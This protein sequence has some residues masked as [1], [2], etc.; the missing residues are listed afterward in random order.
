[1]DSKLFLV[2]LAATGLM[3]CESTSPRAPAPAAPARSAPAQPSGAT[4]APAHGSAAS[5]AKP[6]EVPAAKADAPKTEVAM[7]EVA[8][9]AGTVE[10]RPP[11]GVPAPVVE[12]KP[13]SKPATTV[14][15]PAKEATPPAT[16][17]LVEGKPAAPVAAPA[18]APD[19]SPSIFGEPL[20]VNGKRV[21]DN[22]I[23]RYLIYGPCRLMLEMYRIDLI[24]QDEFVRRAAREADLVIRPQVTAYATKQASA[25]IEGKTFATPEEKQAAYD[26]ALAKAT[27]EARSLPELAKPWREAY[28]AEYGR[29]RETMA[30]SDVEFQA[31]YKRTLDEFRGNYPVLDVEAEVSRAFRTV[32]WY[33]TNLKQTLLFDKVFYPEDPADWPETTVE[34]VRADS[35]ET[36]L[37]DAVDSYQKRRAHADKTG[38][39][40]PKED[41]IYTQ[42]MRQIVRDALYSTIDFKTAYDGL[43]DD[44][45]MTA[46]KN[47]DGKPELVVTTAEVWEK[48]KD[49]VTPAEIEEAKQWYVTSIATADRLKADGHLLD[50]N[51]RKQA[52]ADLMK[53]FAGTYI[54]IEILATQQYAFPSTETYKEYFCLSKGFEALTAPK[55]VSGPDGALAAPLRDHLD[56]ANR[57]MG[58]GQVDVEC[59]LV[60]AFDIPHFKW[61][62]VTW[63]D[64]RKKAEGIKAQIDANL[65]ANKAQREAA[66]KARA[67]GKEFT[68]DPAVLEPYVFWT[69]MMDD[70]SEFWDPPPPEKGKSSTVGMKNRGRFGL[71]YRN[72]LAS[73]V[74]ETA[75]S[76]WVTG[77]SITDRTFFDQPEGVVE[78]PYKHPY[79]YLLTRVTR[80][81]PPT[82]PLN[83]SDPKKLDP[84]VDDYLRVAFVTYAK[85][86]VAQADVK[87]FKAI[88]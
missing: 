3:A 41:G 27:S 81:L 65:A 55:L 84:L 4:P 15:T 13:E 68:P 5:P 76:H 6:A 77:N 57:S 22:D 31:E 52:L 62:N 61:K 88:E 63:A 29:V 37:T 32:D 86:A 20:I 14:V 66:D 34:S 74:G 36:L 9:P 79:G 58:L 67:E 70:H 64:T 8:R 80:R 51:G 18:K 82:Y 19:M 59:L 16:V 10:G 2:L 26:A 23:K 72:D 71:R 78:G 25:A 35:G 43:P 48:V 69:K 56:R 47:G 21:S 17:A 24:V 30:I 28:D 75:Y 12:A 73:Y 83:P 11:E 39:P 53:Q 46:D 45:V 44:I 38:E 49:T 85:E 54:N 33:R 42:M 60:S 40:L 50:E 87:G 1:M 7:T